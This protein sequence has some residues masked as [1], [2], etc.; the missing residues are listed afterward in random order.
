MPFPQGCIDYLLPQ[1]S[2]SPVNTSAWA[3]LEPRFFDLFSQLLN[4]KH[5]LETVNQITVLATPF[6][7]HGSF[8]A[9]KQGKKINIYATYRTDLPINILIHTLLLALY[10]AHV[11]Q[12]AETGTVYWRDRQNLVK[13][14]LTHSAFAELLPNISHYNYN[15]AL[16]A[17]SQ[18]YLTSLGFPSTT[19]ALNLDPAILPALQISCRDIRVNRL[20]VPV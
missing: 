15:P 17:D 8:Y 9:R 16:L 11:R 4:H 6:G 2:P 1:L 13:Y 10:K 20:P 19:S 12:D 7:S 14:L 18:K 3:D 5:V